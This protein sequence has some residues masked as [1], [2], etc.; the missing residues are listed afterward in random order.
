MLLTCSQVKRGSSVANDSRKSSLWL[1]PTTR[2]VSEHF[3]DIAEDI[4]EEIII[5]CIAFFL[6]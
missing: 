2:G 4:V 1:S 5:S 6:A 3:E